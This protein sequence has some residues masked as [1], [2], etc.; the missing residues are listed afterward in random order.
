MGFLSAFNIGWYDVG[1]KRQNVIISSLEFFQFSC[2]VFLDAGIKDY[3]LALFLSFLTRILQLSDK[4][5]CLCSLSL[6]FFEIFIET[7]F[8]TKLTY[9]RNEGM[10]LVEEKRPF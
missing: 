4:K 9:F 1:R 7:K 5:I 6:K 8:R 2:Y 10:R 3:R